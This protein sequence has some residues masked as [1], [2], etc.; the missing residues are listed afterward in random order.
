MQQQDRMFG[1]RDR[2]LV[3]LIQDYECGF[4]S[5]STRYALAETTYRRPRDTIPIFN[6]DILFEFF[7]SNG[8]YDN[9]HVLSPGIHSAINDAIVRGTPKEKIVLLYAR[10]HAERNCLSFLDALI[11][12]ALRLAPDFWADWRFIAVGENF[13]RSKLRACERIEILGRLGLKP[14]AALASRAA[15]GIS[16]MIS[17]HPSYPPLE[18]AAAGVQVITN[19][20][21]VRDLAKVHDNIHSFEE[22]DLEAV[23]RKLLLVAEAWIARPDLGWTGKPKIDWFF[24]GR[25][26]LA[27]LA[28]SVAQEIR[29]RSS[30]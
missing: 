12:T 11:E 14:Y 7:K 1:R 8:Y 30:A 21:G 24:E 3:Y 9:G 5:W 15:L 29:L 16:L 17:P 25:S 2:S 28:A 4:S 6:T 23:A 13:D 20:Y 26:N 19:T 22:F 10:P 18:M 27:Q